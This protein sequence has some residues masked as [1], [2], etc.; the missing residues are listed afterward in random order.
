MN[1]S[2]GRTSWA[3]CSAWCSRCTAAMAFNRLVDRRHDAKNPRTAG[4]HLPA[5]TLS[6]GS[7]VLFTLASLLR[8]HRLHPSLSR[9]R[10]SQPLA[11]LPLGAG[12][13]L[14][15][16][17]LA[18]EAVYRAVHFWLGAALMLAPV[19]AWIAVKGL[20]D[21]EAPLLLGGAVLF[22][23]AGFDILYACQDAAFDEAEGLFSIPARSE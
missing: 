11:A 10:F 1:R 3:S 17:V 8:V 22:W 9:P 21:L 7:V 12:A 2:A 18:G 5:R 13:P 23:V 15:T 20:A 6:V 14:H 19:A 4:R 16:G